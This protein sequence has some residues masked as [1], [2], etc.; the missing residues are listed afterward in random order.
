MNG[1]DGNDSEN[2]ISIKRK[3]NDAIQLNIKQDVYVYEMINSVMLI[4][5]KVFETAKIN[6]SEEDILNS[7]FDFLKQEYKNRFLNIGEAYEK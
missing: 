5:N 7:K 3:E 2:I 4:L 6:V 1:Y